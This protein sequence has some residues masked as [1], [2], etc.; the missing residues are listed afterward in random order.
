MVFQHVSYY[1]FAH[2]LTEFRPKI[3]FEMLQSYFILDATGQD[4]SCLKMAVTSFR[5]CKYISN[6]YTAR[7]T[8]EDGSMAADDVSQAE[9]ALRYFITLGLSRTL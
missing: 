6:D 9:L 5:E 7:L 2:A 3:Y 1:F 8:L 4:V